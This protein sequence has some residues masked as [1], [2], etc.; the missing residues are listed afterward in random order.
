MIIDQTD[1][2]H[3]EIVHHSNGKIKSNF[4]YREGKM[5][6]SEDGNP[7]Y[8]EYYEAGQIKCTARYRDGKEA[9]SDDG[10]P[11]RIEYFDCGAIR[12]GRSAVHGFLF[13][14][15]VTALQKAALV[16]RVAALLAPVDTAVVPAGMPP[17]WRK[18]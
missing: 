11:G 6:D 12:H 14:D 1:N 15:Q 13:A 8:I 5:N 10:T 17:N 4:Y 2:R 3:V 9:D 16:R 18:G 7:A